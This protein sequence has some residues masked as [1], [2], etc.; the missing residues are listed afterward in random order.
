MNKPWGK[1][2]EESA[3]IQFSALRLKGEMRIMNAMKWSQLKGTIIPYGKLIEIRVKGF[4]KKNN[5]IIE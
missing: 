3:V 2:F 4:T 5:I 1:Y